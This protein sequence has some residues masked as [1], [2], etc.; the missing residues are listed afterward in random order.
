MTFEMRDPMTKS[1]PV[2]KIGYYTEN[3]F[4]LELYSEGVKCVLL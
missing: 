4:A 3:G 1:F 2:E